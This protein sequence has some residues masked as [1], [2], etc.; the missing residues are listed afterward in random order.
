MVFA[1]VAFDFYT[2][3]LR[4][5]MAGTGVQVIQ[6]GFNDEVTFPEEFN[7]VTEVGIAAGADEVSNPDAHISVLMKSDSPGD[8]HVTAT[9][10]C[11]TLRFS[12]REVNRFY[13]CALAYILKSGMISNSPSNR[14]VKYLSA[15]ESKT[16]FTKCQ[17]KLTTVQ[18]AKLITNGMA[19][20]RIVTILVATKINY[21]LTNHHVGQKSGELVSY[22]GKLVK[23][24]NLEMDIKE[25]RVAI[26]TLGK[27]I[28]TLAVLSKLGVKGVRDHETFDPSLKDFKINASEDIAMRISA[29]PAGTAHITTYLAIVRHASRSIYC[30]L[31][32]PISS[33]KD[34]IALEELILQNPCRFHIGSVFLTGEP[35]LKQDLFSESTKENLSAYI[36]AVAPSSSLAKAGVIKPL[37]EVTG[38]T[39]YKSITSVMLTI[40][41][42]AAGVVQQT[43]LSIANHGEGAG[44]LAIQV[45]A[46]KASD[47]EEAFQ[48][49][50]NEM[51][52]AIR[53]YAKKFNISRKAAITEGNFNISQFDNALNTARAVKVVRVNREIRATAVT[54]LTEKSAET[55]TEESSDDTD[56]DNAEDDKDEEDDESDDKDG[57]STPRNDS[58]D[59][60]DDPPGLEDAGEADN[61]EAEE[62]EQSEEDFDDKKDNGSEDDE[63]NLDLSAGLAE[64]ANNN[65]NPFATVV[66][67]V[68]IDPEEV[69][70]TPSFNKKR[71]HV[72]SK[73]S[74]GKN[75]KRSKKTTKSEKKKKK[76]KGYPAFN[77]RA[78]KKVS[79]NI[80][81]T[82]FIKPFE[83]T[84]QTIRN[85]WEPLPQRQARLPRSERKTYSDNT[86]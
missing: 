45:G 35:M 46:I 60:D 73:K 24:Y 56:D 54:N 26:W 9:L 50:R 82:S 48:K 55:K 65:G 16:H 42:Q 19:V 85:K 8:V 27:M 59:E 21:W 7:G 12:D 75:K 83:K 77:T 5:N 30:C 4:K 17:N 67:E 28:S 52:L 20:S 80:S 51:N 32:P 34:V 18:I 62:G 69:V 39:V 40:E 6:D 2:R 13:N 23:S 14:Y 66:S 84:F 86:T 38:N 72:K 11:Q 49:R 37:S 57:D 68:E 43:C 41:K 81:I 64:T 22:V 3:S 74:S 31:V 47:M 15:A 33:L 61:F 78:K 44:G 58:D 70:T 76:K 29:A 25:L 71:K 36:H 53:Q 10:K 1:F 63:N 79:L